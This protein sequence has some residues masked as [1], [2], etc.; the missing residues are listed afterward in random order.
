MTRLAAWRARFEATVL[1]GAVAFILLSV[2]DWFKVLSVTSVTLDDAGA[3]GAIFSALL[4]VAGL[5]LTVFLAMLGIVTSMDDD[6]PV[7]RIM[8]QEMRN[9]DELVHRLIGPV[10]SLLVVA[11]AAIV[12]LMLPSLQLDKLDAKQLQAAREARQWMALFPSFAVSVSIGLFVQTAMTARLLASVLLFKPRTHSPS[13]THEA[14]VA[15]VKA[16]REAAAA[17]RDENQAADMVSLA[18]T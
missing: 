10:F 7:I 2:L 4:T 3:K 16:R 5:F 18:M 14:A 15:R 6:K 1:V 13:D 12:C 8:K 9:Y 11:V 17:E